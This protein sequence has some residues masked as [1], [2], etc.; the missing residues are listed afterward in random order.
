MRK[1]QR[2]TECRIAARF[3][4]CES[5]CVCALCVDR[6]SAAAFDFHATANSL[7]D[8][9]E[10]VLEDAL[11]DVPELEIVHAVS[12][13]DGAVARRARMFCGGP[14]SEPRGVVW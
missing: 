7:L 3:P 8:H 1:G 14:E 4:H 5:V 11:E 13:S 9:V 10:V 12:V 2:A 6:S